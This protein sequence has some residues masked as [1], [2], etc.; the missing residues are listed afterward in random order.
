MQMAFNNALLCS[1]FVI[2]A[3]LDMIVVITSLHIIGH[4]CCHYII[5]HDGC[6]DI[7]ARHWT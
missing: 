2:S 3:S 4:D 5:K 1:G 7:S 6:Q